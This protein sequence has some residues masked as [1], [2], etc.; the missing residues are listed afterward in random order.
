VYSKLVL[1]KSTLKENFAQYRYLVSESKDALADL[2]SKS[3]ILELLFTE[4]LATLLTTADQVGHN[5]L[6]WAK[7]NI[8]VDFVAVLSKL[9]CYLVGKASKL[10]KHDSIVRLKVAFIN[11]VCCNVNRLSIVRSNQHHVFFSH[12]VDYVAHI[13]VVAFVGVFNRLKDWGLITTF[14]G[15]ITLFK[16]VSTTNELNAHV[17]SELFSGGNF[18]REQFLSSLSVALVAVHD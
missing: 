8:F 10:S 18:H 5:L 17:V 15:K 12:V 7:W 11:Q 4:N 2:C 16:H 14:L 13:V 3:F 6:G 9:V 1:A